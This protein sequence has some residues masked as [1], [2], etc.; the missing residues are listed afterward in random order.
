M[1]RFSG[2]P[3]TAAESTLP[4]APSKVTLPPASLTIYEFDIR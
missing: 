4:Q 3:A 1:G 2:P